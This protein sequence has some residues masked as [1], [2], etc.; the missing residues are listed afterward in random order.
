MGYRGEPPNTRFAIDGRRIRITVPRAELGDTER[1]MVGAS[2]WS[3]PVLLD[4]MPWRVVNL[5]RPDNRVT[6]P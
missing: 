6:A 5:T 1:I 4:R 2:A 3:G